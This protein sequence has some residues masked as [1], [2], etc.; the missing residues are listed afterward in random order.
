MMISVVYQNLVSEA[1]ICDY[2]PQNTMGYDYVSMLHTSASYNSVCTPAS[3]LS[4]ETHGFPVLNTNKTQ[5]VESTYYPFHLYN[6][7]KRNHRI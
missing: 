1:V 4:S 2:V 3:L 7:A 6:N 5:T